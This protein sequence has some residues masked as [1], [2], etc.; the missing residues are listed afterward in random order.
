MLDQ[1][2]AQHCVDL[3][4]VYVQGLSNGAFMTSALACVYADRFAAASPVAG[5]QAP[6]GCKPARPVPVV[7]FH[8]T[9]DGYVGY[10]GGLGQRALDLPAPDGS[11]K[12]LSDTG[13]LPKS[14]KAGP[15]VPETT[16]AWAKRNGCAVKATTKKVSTDVTRFAYSTCRGGSDVQ[17]YRITKG[18]HTWPGSAFSQNIE[19]IVGRTTMTIDA[20]EIMWAFFQQHPLGRAKR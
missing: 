15:S 20:N 4:R 6:K 14:V 17:L 13:G 18:G 16:K 8:G 12:K 10:D 3:N 2:E 9:A 7:A 19:S 1:V 5:I 11:G